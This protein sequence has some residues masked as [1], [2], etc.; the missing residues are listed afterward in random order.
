MVVLVPFKPV[1]LVLGLL[2]GL[3]FVGFI[4]S[5]LLEGKAPFTVDT[6]ATRRP[7][8]KQYAVRATLEHKHPH[9]PPSGR[10]Q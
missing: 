1:V 6:C 4:G 2:S 3:I 9:K 7:V 5:S 8:V 10:T